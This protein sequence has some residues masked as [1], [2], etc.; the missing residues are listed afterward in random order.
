MEWFILG[1]LFSEAEKQEKELNK[2]S[3]YISTLPRKT[4][5]LDR[6]LKRHPFIDKN[7]PWLIGVPIGLTPLWL[8]M[9]LLWLAGTL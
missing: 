2:T 4:T 1:W 9:L 6:W 7:W 8:S 5:K 3:Y